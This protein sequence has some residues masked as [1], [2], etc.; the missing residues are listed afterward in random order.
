MFI[1]LLINQEYKEPEIHI[2]NHEQN[3]ETDILMQ[4]V[5]QAV[6]FTINGYTE[7]GVE[8]LP[9]SSII[10][11]YTENKKVYAAT[12][13]GVYRLHKRLYELEEIL[14]ARKFVRISNTDIINLKYIK[15]LDT[16]IG[17]TIKVKLEGGLE[18]YV[19][20]RHIADIKKVLGIGR[21]E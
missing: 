5:K 11:I 9:I 19:S 15:H 4:A 8:V 16:T 6:D 1:K 2:C 18:A 17:G 13:A 20:R 12:G 7:G 3:K 14:D 10:R 21:K